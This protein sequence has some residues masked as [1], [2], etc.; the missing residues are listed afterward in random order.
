MSTFTYIFYSSWVFTVYY[1]SRRKYPVK[2]VQFRTWNLKEQILR[3]YTLESLALLKKNP[4]QQHC[5]NKCHFL[6]F[7][8]AKFNSTLKARSKSLSNMLKRSINICL[9]YAFADLLKK[10]QFFFSMLVTQIYLNFRLLKFYFTLKCIYFSSRY[11]F[12]K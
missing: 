2:T 4:Q 5:S 7:V 10:P 9:S 8:R 11:H 1:L 12:I 3:V 6:L